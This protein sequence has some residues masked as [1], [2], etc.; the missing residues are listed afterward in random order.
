MFYQ[1]E[2]TACPRFWWRARK[3]SHPTGLLGGQGPRRS[4]APTGAI[5]RASA[6]SVSGQSRRNH[7]WEGNSSGQAAHSLTVSA[8][9]PNG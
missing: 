6:F 1:S 8:R 7:Q 3:T 2:I 4:F 5:V 9:H